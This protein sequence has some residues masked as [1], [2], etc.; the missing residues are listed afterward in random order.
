MIALRPLVFLFSLFLLLALAGGTSAQG[1]LTPAEDTSSTAEAAEAR[2][3]GEAEALQRLILTLEDPHTRERLLE[4]LRALQSLQA[5]DSQTGGAATPTAADSPRDED[6]DAVNTAAR[7]LAQSAEQQ[8]Q[9][10]GT[11]FDRVMQALSQVQRVPGWLDDQVNRP[12]RQAFWIEIF[13]V[14][15]G[16]P[17]LVALLARWLVGLVLKSSLRRLRD[18][19]PT[20][21]Q[22]RVSTAVLRTFLEALQVAVVLGAGWAVLLLVPRSDEATRIAMLVIQAIALQTAVGVAARLLLAPLSK[23]LRPLPLSDQTAA[24]LYIWILRLSL[25]A[26][27]G[28]VFSRI[29]IPLGASWTG[30][31]AIEIAFATLFAGL[32]IVFIVQARNMV[33]ATI[34][35]RAREGQQPSILRKRFSEIWHI[36]AI[37]YVL[38]VFGIFVSGA[39]DGFG[40]LLESTIIT[41]AAITLAVLLSFLLERALRALFRVDDDLDRRFPGLKQRSN[42]YRP[43]LSRGMTILLWIV[44]AVVI[45]EGWDIDIYTALDTETRSALLH[46]LAMIALVIIV[47]SLIWEFSASAIARALSGTNPDGSPRAASGRTKTLLPLLR[48][49]ILI[50]LVIFGGMIILSEIGVDIA[51]LLASAG[52]I[53]IAIGFGSQ[54]LVR[55]IITG[56]FILIED[57]VSVG[58]VV[59]V[60]NHTGVVEDLSL[61]TIR[62][63]DLSGAIHVVPFGDVTSVVNMTRDYAYALL[64]IGVAYREST[65]RVAGMMVEVGDQLREDPDWADKIMEPIEIFGVNE[66]ADSAVIVRARLKTRPM[67]QWS[68]KREYHRRI[69]QRF[70]AEGIEIPFPHTTLYFGVDHEGKA[71]AA[72]LIMEAEENAKIDRQKEQPLVA[73]PPEEPGVK[74]QSEYPEVKRDDDD[75]DETVETKPSKP[76]E[77]KP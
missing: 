33:A 16:L 31:E 64:D 13:T 34:R 62:L 38:L 61:R 22:G 40:F 65:D 25:V 48:R 12:E 76:Q 45:L 42:L 30:A 9:R 52:V 1:L 21:P 3:S 75:K 39:R 37:I 59:T 74:P 14:G 19:Q 58:D 4:D 55:D 77:P 20:T 15:L 47:G 41:I 6:P 54:A 23:A 5:V 68:V 35:G 46:R 43:L 28:F 73:D 7:T 53:G 70:D 72:R 60:S 69:K 32:V 2:P 8:V 24:Y 27:A 36:L 18:S 50:V 17:L 11:I 56:L 51:P 63:R 26:I 49:T 57:T 10:V 71:P 66:L 67:D 29:A 44:A